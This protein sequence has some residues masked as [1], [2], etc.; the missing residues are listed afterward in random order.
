MDVISK[1][2]IL[3]SYNELLAIRTSVLGRT[4]HLARPFFLNHE[5][6]Q[7]Y[8]VYLYIILPHS[9]KTFEP[10]RHNQDMRPK[11]YN[12][13]SCLVLTMNTICFWNCSAFITRFDT[14]L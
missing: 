12:C 2:R 11:F 1:L 13:Q 7:A 14:L 6:S 3:S 8:L 10:T 9:Q 4:D 5:F